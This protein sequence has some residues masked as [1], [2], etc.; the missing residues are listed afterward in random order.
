[1]DKYTLDLNILLQLNGAQKSPHKMSWKLLIQ[2]LCRMY[3]RI[4]IGH[5]NILL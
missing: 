2:I 3:V 1:M 4:Y 5:Y